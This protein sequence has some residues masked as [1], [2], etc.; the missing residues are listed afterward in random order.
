MFDPNCRLGFIKQ[1]KHYGSNMWCNNV[2]VIIGCYT[3][4]Q[5][6]K[7]DSQTLC[8]KTSHLLQTVF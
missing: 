7:T 2:F 5:G 6:R 1:L 3:M 8:G 4:L